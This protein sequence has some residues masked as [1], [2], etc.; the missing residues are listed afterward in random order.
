MFTR[1]GISKF[2]PISS[3]A[4]QVGRAVPKIGKALCGALAWRNALRRDTV[5]KV[6]ATT[7]SCHTEITHYTVIHH[8][9]RHYMIIICNMCLVFCFHH[10]FLS[11]QGTGGQVGSWES[12]ISAT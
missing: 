10:L 9:I 3:M 7:Q 8:Y 1:P 4:W 11:F 12:G 5:K 2:H 6:S